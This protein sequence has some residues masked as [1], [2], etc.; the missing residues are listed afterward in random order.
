MSVFWSK[1]Y[2]ATSTDDLLQAMKIGRQSLYDTF[3]DKKRLYVETLERY[4]RESV[5]GHIERLRSGASPLAGIEALLVGLVSP[6]E[7]TRKMGCMGVNSVSEFGNTDLDLVKLRTRSSR[8]LHKPLIERLRAAQDA[9]EIGRS[10]DIEDAA[11]FVA[12]T[13]LGLQVAARAGESIQALRK[14]AG[15]AVAGLRNR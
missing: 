13:M 9:G 10:V 8:L 14:A 15:F 3:G 2:A 11:R 4:Q 6:D 12:M 1:G 7:T 5:A